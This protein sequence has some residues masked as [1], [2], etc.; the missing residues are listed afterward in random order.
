MTDPR[1]NAHSSHMP[2]KLSMHT[3][4]LEAQ[5]E[6][7]NTALQERS[8]ALTEAEA[9][10]ERLQ[11][12]LD[13]LPAARAISPVSA[14]SNHSEAPSRAKSPTALAQSTP[15]SEI[16]SARSTTS[17]KKPGMLGGVTPA[18]LP[19]KSL[20]LPSETITRLSA[21]FPA[22]PS[23]SVVPDPA[24]PGGPRDHDTA[25]MKMYEDEAH[26]RIVA[27]ER[28]LDEARLQNEAAEMRCVDAIFRREC[29]FLVNLMRALVN[30]LCMCM[31]V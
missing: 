12:E 29:F 2:D 4:A 7:V 3:A 18:P 21:N 10:I 23:R 13:A 9:E 16:L 6:D 8:T 20:P 26:A 14:R 15:R 30:S 31:R 17:L 11:K 5:L 24:F 28:L 19:P 1:L 27:L 22:P 25:S